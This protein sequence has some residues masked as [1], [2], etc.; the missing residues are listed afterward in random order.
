MCCTNLGGW[1]E[2][3][4]DQFDS[5]CRAH[6]G[7]MTLRYCQH[8]MTSI[9]I[10]EKRMRSSMIVTKVEVD[11]P[12]QLAIL[13]QHAYIWRRIFIQSAKNTLKTYVV[14]DLAHM[15]RITLHLWIVCTIACFGNDESHGICGTSNVLLV[16]HAIVEDYVLLGG[17]KIQ[18]QFV[19]HIL[20]SW[21]HEQKYVR[22]FSNVNA[23][24]HGS[25]LLWMFQWISRNVNVSWK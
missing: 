23:F 10:K 11:R 21:V 20:D 3:D 22:N 8:L 14:P 19:L 9:L 4:N 15:R 16:S 5:T 12:L 2:V 1:R 13:V 7:Q 25:I 17:R 6:T 24:V 18:A